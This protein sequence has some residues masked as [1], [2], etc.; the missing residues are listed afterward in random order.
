MDKMTMLEHIKSEVREYELILFEYK[1]RLN[2]LKELAQASQV[3]ITKVLFNRVSIYQLFRVFDQ[4]LA[5]DQQVQLDSIAQ[6]DIYQNVK[7]QVNIMKDHLRNDELKDAIDDIHEI[8][9]LEKTMEGQQ[10]FAL[11]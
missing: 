6:E 11:T 1:Q 8:H 7:E 4:V 5:N 2:M 10:G 9:Q 3:N